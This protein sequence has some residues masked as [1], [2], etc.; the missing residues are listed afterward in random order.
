MEKDCIFVKTTFT[1]KLDS[2]KHQIPVK[3]SVEALA[4]NTISSRAISF[5]SFLK[6]RPFNLQIIFTSA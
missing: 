2:C 5:V 3:H 6:P 1:K 4:G